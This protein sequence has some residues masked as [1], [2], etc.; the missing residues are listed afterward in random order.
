MGIGGCQEVF[1]RPE[2][3]RAALMEKQ[4]GVCEPFGETHVVS[5]DNACKSKLLLESLDQTAEP[6]AMMGSTMVVGSS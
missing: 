5:D 6:L 3:R 4:D 2:E 1:E